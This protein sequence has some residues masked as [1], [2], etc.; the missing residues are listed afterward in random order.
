MKVVFGDITKVKAGCIVNAADTHLKHLGGV[1]LTIVRAGSQEIQ[2]E[3]DKIGFCPIGKAVV[4][5]AGKL[6]YQCII[7]VPTI[8]WQTGQKATTEDIFN[9]TV[10]ALEIAKEKKIKTIAFSLLG[11]G[12]VGLDKERVKAQLQ[13]AEK[14]FPE[15]EIVLCIKSQ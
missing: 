6:P 3:S 15:L 12:V 2:K 13:K 14:L 8:D 11:A 4:T 9:G 5:G 10:A 7:H 1:A